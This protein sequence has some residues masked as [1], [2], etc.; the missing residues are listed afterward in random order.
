M[1]VPVILAMPSV[2]LVFSKVICCSRNKIL[3][4]QLSNWWTVVEISIQFSVVMEEV[5]V[6][7]LTLPWIMDFKMKKIT[8]I[9]GKKALV[10]LNLDKINFH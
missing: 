3:H 5:E 1:K 6:G 7:P 8:L 4:S 2:Q 9:Q 10:K